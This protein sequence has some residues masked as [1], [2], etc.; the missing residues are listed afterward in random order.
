MGAL[1]KWTPSRELARLGNEFE[2]LVERLGF[3]R[4]WLGRFPLAREFFGED[5]KAPARPALETRVEEGKFIVRTDLPG[6]ELKN[7][8][9]K[10]MG[11]V[12]TIEGS[13]EEKRETKETDY[14]RRE[15]SYGSFARSL[16]LPAGIKAEDLK[17]TYKD[18][19]LELVAAMPKEALPKEV[20]IQVE[21]PKKEPD[22]KN[23][24]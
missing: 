8:K 13:R 16:S 2:N 6:I 19:V 24:A 3:D 23:A 22:H 14:L 20:T 7:V 10:V 9:I 15:I 21:G 5:Q 18:G 4:S 12:L 1:E 11:D 17:A